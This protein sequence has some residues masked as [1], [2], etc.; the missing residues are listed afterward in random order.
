MTFEQN[1]QKSIFQQNPEKTYIDKLLSK[2]EIERTKALV[3]K[4]DLSRSEVLELLHM[5]S[6]AESKLW[7]LGD[8]DRYVLLK[9][10]VWIREFVKIAEIMYDNK[11]NMLV[12]NNTCATCKGYIH[13]KMKDFNK[14]SCLI[15]I[16]EVPLSERS[17]RILDNNEKLIEH[18]TKF[19]VE[20][21][22]NI[23]RTT[24]SLGGTGF[25]ELLKNK[26]EVNYPSNNLASTEENKTRLWGLGKK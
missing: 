17:L 6:S 10:F 8:W 16:K 3:S 18:N 12:K 4:P 26:F 25:L 24:L 13:E 1:L 22:F 23:G 11:E 15:P 9:F 19:L 7:N 2:R 21:Y 5:C 20:L 14:C